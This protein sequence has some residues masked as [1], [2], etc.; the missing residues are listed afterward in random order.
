[1]GFPGTS[2]HLKQQCWV[3]GARG[4]TL[5]DNMVCLPGFSQE[6]DHNIYLTGYQ[7]IHICLC[8]KKYH[9]EFPHMIVE[10]EWYNNLPSASWRPRIARGVSASRRPKAF[11]KIKGSNLNAGEYQCFSL[12]THTHTHTHTQKKRKRERELERN[13]LQSRE[14]SSHSH[15]IPE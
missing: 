12:N 6:T 1:M 10:T 2:E 3:E 5:G 8:G 13:G 15:S 7:A 9:K 4:T 14:T 11:R